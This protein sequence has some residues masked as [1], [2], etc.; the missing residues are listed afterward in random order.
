M[1]DKVKLKGIKPNP[2]NPRVIRDAKF[3]KLVDSLLSFPGM[4]EKRGIVV[5]SGM[6]LGGNQRLRAIEHIARMTSD[7]RMAR[8]ESI[9]NRNPDNFQEPRLASALKAWDEVSDTKSIPASW[10][11]RADDW[12]EAECRE[13]EIRDNVQFGEWDFE[14]L[15]NHWNEIDLNEWMKDFDQMLSDVK[16]DTKYS[17]ILRYN[18]D[19]YQRVM[20]WFESTGLP[21]ELALINLL[22]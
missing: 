4:L 18:E 21:K 15:A 8:L 13:F 16:P 9:A 20:N 3:D 14:A 17:V 6:A 2:D 12:T 22:S 7:E 1:S 11:L 10:V 19:D 5:R